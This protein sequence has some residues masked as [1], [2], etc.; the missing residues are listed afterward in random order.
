MTGNEIYNN[1][2]YSFAVNSQFDSDNLKFYNN[3]INGVRGTVSKDQ[4]VAFGIAVGAYGEFQAQ[5]LQ[6]YHNTIVNCAAA[7]ISIAS[8]GDQFRVQGNIFTDNILAYNGKD[9][10]GYQIYLQDIPGQVNA[11]IFRN[12]LLYSPGVTA[13][14]YYGHDT[15]DNYPHSVAEFNAESGTA[16]DVITNNLVGDPVFVDL[17]NSNFHIGAGSAAIDKGID[18]GLT[19][20]YDGKTVNNPPDIGAY[21][22]P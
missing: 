7:G 10:H 19:N 11:Q 15:V 17:T 16:G 12:N 5:N 4:L 20:D 22:Y 21:E 18:V 8:F 13:L 9:N 6:F 3:I 1:Y 2:A 14:V